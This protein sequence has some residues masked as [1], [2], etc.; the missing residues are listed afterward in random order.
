MIISHD[1]GTTADK[2]PLHDPTAC[3]PAGEAYRRTG[4]RVSASYTLAKVMWVRDH[5]PDVWR[6]PRTRGPNA[7]REHPGAGGPGAPR[8]VGCHGLHVAPRLC[9][10]PL[11][12]PLTDAAAGVFNDQAR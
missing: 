1:I 7:R 9:R 2:A 4:H 12:D 8:V 11:S 5:A 6:R 10:E 3:I